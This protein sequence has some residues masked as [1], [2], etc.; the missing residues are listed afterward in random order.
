[1]LRHVSPGSNPTCFTISWFRPWLGALGRCSTGG[2]PRFHRIP[3]ASNPRI[4]W[5]PAKLLVIARNGL[6]DEHLNALEVQ[7]SMGH[8]NE[9]GRTSPSKTGSLDHFVLSSTGS[10][11]TLTEP[12]DPHVLGRWTHDLMV[13]P[14]VGL[15]IAHT[16]TL[17]QVFG[18]RPFQI[19]RWFFSFV[20]ENGVVR[21]TKLEVSYTCG[22]LWKQLQRYS[23]TNIRICICIWVHHLHIIHWGKRGTTKRPKDISSWVRNTEWNQLSFSDLIINQS[24]FV[25]LSRF[26][27]TSSSHI[28]PTDLAN[29]RAVPWAACWFGLCCDV[30]GGIL[31]DFW[32]VWSPFHSV[33]S[34]H[35]RMF[36]AFF[37]EGGQLLLYT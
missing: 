33:S 30:G 23:Y 2:Y 1:M 28:G 21:W 27:D 12:I 29:C 13:A 24:V 8:R 18:S 19:H 17:A 25:W 36:C 32:C 4:T 22:M 14:Q 26:A 31:Q 37:F 20:V 3:F 11:L 10:I 5:R 15:M 35:V 6:S 16:H 34:N 7:L 9:I